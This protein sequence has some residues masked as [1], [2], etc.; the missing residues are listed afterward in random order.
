M[1]N[2]LAVISMYLY[3]GQGL[4]RSLIER[5]DISTSDNLSELVVENY[6]M[7]FDFLD[8]CSLIKAAAPPPSVPFLEFLLPVL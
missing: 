8:S 7:P 6:I 1:V 2:L 4:L 5:L 3:E